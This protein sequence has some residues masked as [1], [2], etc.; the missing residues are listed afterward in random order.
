MDIQG[1]F[2]VTNSPVN[3]FIDFISSLD[4]SDV[5]D[6]EI[7]SPSTKII[8]VGDMMYKVKQDT[9]STSLFES[10]QSKQE[11][12]ANLDSDTQLDSPLKNEEV[13][14]FVHVNV[15]PVSSDAF[16]AQLPT[17]LYSFIREL[18]SVVK[19]HN[20]HDNSIEYAF[21]FKQLNLEV[22]I[23]KHEEL[24]KI[25]IFVGDDALKSEFTKD[26]Q[27]LMVSILQSKLDTDQLDVEFVFDFEKSFEEENSSEDNNSDQNAQSQNL[28][29]DSQPNEESL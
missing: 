26:R 9:E 14:P 27:E 13:I 1:D 12:T 21:K 10:N 25:V 15:A 24:L 23:K 8:E 3:S 19:L 29:D 16:L 5:Y 4:F 6:Q 28:D 22:M 2:K 20:A 7:K 18:V 17:H 11:S